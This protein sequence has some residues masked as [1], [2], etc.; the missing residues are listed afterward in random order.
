[1]TTTATLSAPAQ[2]SSATLADQIVSNLQSK[3]GPVR[4][5]LRIDVEEDVATLR[6]VAPSFYQK[7][8]WLHAAASVRGISR[9]VDHIEVISSPY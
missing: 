3:H 5:R 8:L 7:Q 2:S 9:V 6:G 1:M 4:T